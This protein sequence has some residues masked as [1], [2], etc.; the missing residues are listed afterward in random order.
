[1]ILKPYMIQQVGDRDNRSWS[2]TENV[3]CLQAN[4]QSKV[5]LLVFI[6]DKSYG[7]ESID[8]TQNGESKRDSPGNE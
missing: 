8:G 2:I 6:K 5:P 3:P 1:M 7:L 4:A